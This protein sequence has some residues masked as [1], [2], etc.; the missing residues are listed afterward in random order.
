MALTKIGKE[1]ITG[2]SNSANANAI[3]IDSSEQVGIGITP[4]VQ[5]QVEESSTGDAV[6]IARGGNYILIGGSGSGTQYVKGYEATVAFGNKYTGNTTFLTGDTERMR[7]NAAGNVGIGITTPDGKV[8]IHTATAG[9]ITAN[10]A[11]DELVLENSGDAGLTILS[12]NAN[13][14]Q[15]LL[16][17]PVAIAGGIIRWTGDD[18]AVKIGTNNTG[19][20]LRFHVGAFSEVMRINSSG[21]VGIGN[22]NPN[23]GRLH[24]TNSTGAIGYFQ[25]TQAASNVENIIL[26]STQTN[27]SANLSFQINNGTS[28]KGQVRLNGDNS[29]AFHNGTSLTE[30]MR[31]DASGNVFIGNTAEF[32]DGTGTGDKGIQLNPIGMVVATRNGGISGIFGRQASDGDIIQFRKDGSAIGSISLIAGNNLT[33]GSTST[34]HAGLM[35]GGHSIVPMEAGS[36]ADGTINFGSPTKRFQNLFLSGGVRL[37]GTGTANELDDYEEGTHTITFTNSS[38]SP[39]GAGAVYT[40]IGNVV[41]YIGSFTFPSSSD[42]TAINISIPFTS[43]TNNSLGQIFTN[44]VTNKVLFTGGGGTNYMR[45]YPDNSFGTNSYANLSGVAIYFTITYKTSA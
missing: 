33:I 10:A 9:S 25:S 14:S 4:T 19:G 6:K 13:N 28:A 38:A 23:G 41:N 40:K 11:A 45:I 44:G 34:D 29:L 12:P 24:V 31:I 16:G 42:S 22:T 5:F 1:G 43:A 32:V 15:I 27:S 26:N 20:T 7:I 8:H 39:S 17:S 3:T 30:R 37:G 36:Q 21:N 2:I 18:N 35:F